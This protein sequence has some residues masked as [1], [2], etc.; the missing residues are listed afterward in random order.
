VAAGVRAVP[1]RD[2]TLQPRPA[3]SRSPLVRPGL[4]PRLASTSHVR[5][6]CEASSRSGFEAKRL[7]ACTKV[8]HEQQ[9]LLWFQWRGFKPKSRVEAGGFIID[10]MN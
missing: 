6:L 8:L 4:R 5:R 2:T 9:E 3:C 7:Q 10:G 1:A